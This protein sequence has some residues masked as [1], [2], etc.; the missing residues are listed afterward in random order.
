MTLKEKI[1]V[2]R[3]CLGDRKAFLHRVNDIL[4]RRWLSNSGPYVQEFEKQIADFTGVRHCVSICNA[5][6]ALEIASKALGF[7]GEVIIPSYTFVA[8][9][10]ALQWQ[11]I[12]PVFADINPETH[13]ISPEAIE[14]MITPRTTGIIGVHVWGRPCDTDAIEMIAKKHGI[15]VMYDASHGFGCSR[16]GKMI[17]GFGECEI[18]SF[19]ATKFINSLEGGAIVTN[20][21][22][23]AYQI[24]MMTNFGFVDYD[25][26]EYLGINGKMNEISAA[27][28]ITNM[29]ILPSIVENNR[30]NYLAYK[31]GL[32]GLKGISI[33]NYDL[34]ESSNFQYVVAMVEEKKCPV[35][36]DQ[37]VDGLHSSNILARKYFW[38]GC[39]NMEPY[40][41]LQPKAGLHLGETAKI[42]AKVIVLPT[43][44]TV[45]KKTVMEICTVIKNIVNK[46]D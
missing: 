34:D 6:A 15:K 39:H 2:G 18:F 23:L 21:D 38:P 22:E 43:G 36:R 11:G 16:R 41:T 33:I 24:R 5:T 8:T 4:E 17:G 26:V 44:Q 30:N 9:A 3:P 32:G 46:N 13:N 10:H 37:L 20:N 28:G 35:T 42:A 1:H 29:E 7:R 12:T 14:Q 40:R 31:D 45:N 19:H 25:R 27:M